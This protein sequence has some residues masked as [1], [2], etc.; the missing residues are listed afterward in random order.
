MFFLAQIID[1]SNFFKTGKVQVRVFKNYNGKFIED[2]SK[3][4]K[5]YININRIAK[6]N[7]KTVVG[8]SEGDEI[9]NMDQQ[10]YI[11]FPVGGLFVLPQ[12]NTLGLVSF[13]ENGTLIWMGS[14]SK[15]ISNKLVIPSDIIEYEGLIDKGELKE[16][17]F[18]GS[19]DSFVF[20]RRSHTEG[21]YDLTK[22]KTN[23]LIVGDNT[24]LSTKFVYG[25]N[26]NKKEK[27]E[28]VQSI[29][30]QQD[31]IFTIEN[32]TKDTKN[33]VVLK[34]DSV[35]LI[36]I[37]QQKEI[38]SVYADTNGII[39]ETSN[40]E[41]KVR[42]LLEKKDIVIT[43]DGNGKKSISFRIDLN[44]SSIT[45]N[46]DEIQ[47]NAKNI[48]LGSGQYNLLGTI[49]SIPIAFENTSLTPIPNIK[50]G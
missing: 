15:S 40:S 47:L 46:A 5:E 45:L 16:S 50:V 30:L 24:K 12:A 33:K 11:F 49:S 32:K 43:A 22:E 39:L 9:S 34:E 27:I 1:N 23:I 14:L 19:G 37:N 7:N 25:W 6:V 31:G 38:S 8:T 21:N 10:A 13:L 20:R 4:S 36:S 35:E 2:F 17:Q 42:I 48:K 26:N 3:N 29:D 44:N 18:S 28:K 41:T